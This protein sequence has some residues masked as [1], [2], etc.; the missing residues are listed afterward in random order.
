MCIFSYKLKKIAHSGLNYHYLQLAFQRGGAEGGIENKLGE[1]ND[2]GHVR[3][4]HTKSVI[5]KI[6]DHFN[7]LNQKE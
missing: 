2:V 4:T 1:K 5:A 6:V 3:A 7:A